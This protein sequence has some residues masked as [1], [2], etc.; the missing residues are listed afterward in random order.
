MFS[1]SVLSLKVKYVWQKWQMGAIVV[2]CA[3]LLPVQAVKAQNNKE[4]QDTARQ[5]TQAQQKAY[6]QLNQFEEQVRSSADLEVDGLIVDETIT[7]IGRDFYDVFHRQWEA[8]PSAKNFT[9][10]IKERPTR[11]NGALI[12]VAL[13]DELLFEQQLQP[14]YDVIEEVAT[15][16]ASGLY[17]YLVRNQLQQQLEAEGNKSREVF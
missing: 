4:V 9:I 12:Q 6:Q 2:A 3:L 15:Y 1:E 17:E 7:K 14:R 10:L 11:G 5:A 16:V 8:P 13:N